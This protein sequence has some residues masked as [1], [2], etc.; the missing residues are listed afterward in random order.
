MYC[1]LVTGIPAAGKSTMAKLLSEKLNLPFI[2]KDSIKELLFD[3]VGFNSRE[4]KVNLGTASMDIMY[5]FAEQLMKCNKPFIL[6]NNF[7][8]S[9]KESLMSILIK[10]SYDVLT[11]TLTGDY[12]KIYQR[13]AERNF[14]PERH[15]GHVVND[16]YP[17]SDGTDREN[18]TLLSYEG[19]LYGIEHRGFDSF[20][21]DGKQ[22]ILDTTDFS[23]L[24]MEKLISKIKNWQSEVTK[25]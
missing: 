9:S 21:A 1:I 7:E 8:Y 11:I 15:R 10:Y 6:E 16:H 23:K 14:S 17:E 13:F 5:Y 18:P 12:E 19:Y 22:I 4:E 24:D 2:S 20:N 25:D 3:T